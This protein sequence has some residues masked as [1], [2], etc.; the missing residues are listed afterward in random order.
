M[1]QNPGTVST[2]LW[3]FTGGP[4]WNNEKNRQE[5]KPKPD[6]DALNGLIGILTS[7]HLRLG[8]YREVVSVIVPKYRSYNLEKKKFI[9]EKNKRVTIETS[10]VCCLADI[11][12]MHL[13]YHANRYGK[14]AIGFHRDAAISAGFNPVFYTLENQQ[15]VQNYQVANAKLRSIYVEGII[16]ELESASSD[17]EGNISD[18]NLRDEDAPPEVD[19]SSVASDLDSLKDD[20]EAIEES[21]GEA[22]SFV[23]TFKKSEF[24]SI[25]CEREWRS[26]K[27]FDFTYDDVAFIV[28]P[29]K[30]GVHKKFVETYAKTLKIPDTIPIVPWEYLLEHYI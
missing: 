23:K 29:K 26:L 5:K 21:I 15:V 14:F 25:Y 12:L 19:F 28:L 11:P 18:L 20:V 10:P 27:Q 7:G 9:T 13:G 1:K 16:D 22:L 8:G 17:L 6:A 30:G 3:H 4:K 2:I 24:S